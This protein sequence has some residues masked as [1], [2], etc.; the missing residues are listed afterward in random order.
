MVNGIHTHTHTHTHLVLGTR[1]TV[2][3]DELLAY[4]QVPIPGCVVQHRPTQLGR[5]RISLKCAKASFLLT[6]SPTVVKPS[7]VPLPF[8]LVCV[9][10]LMAKHMLTTGRVRPLNLLVLT[11]QGAHVVY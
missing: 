3:G 2:M 4:L 10:N 8:M 9:N 6:N 5:G 11:T 1:F 7:V